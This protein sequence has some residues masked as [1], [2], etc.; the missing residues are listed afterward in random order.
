[1]TISLPLG[2]S[3]NLFKPIARLL[4]LQFMKTKRPQASLRLITITQN[5]QSNQNNNVGMFHV[6]G[7]QAVLKTNVLQSSLIPDA[8]DIGL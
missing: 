2:Q 4:K 6:V 3:D 1:M 5:D 8:F 7:S